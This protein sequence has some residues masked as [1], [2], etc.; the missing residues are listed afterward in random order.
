MYTLA[1]VVGSLRKASINKKLALALEKTGSDLFRFAP[2]DIGTIP[3]YNQDQEEDLPAAVQAMKDSIMKADAVL[4]LTPEYNRSI[5]GVLKNVLD[6]G[7]RPYGKNAWAGKPAAM[8]GSSA[9]AIG[10][11]VAQGHLRSVLGVLGMKL[12]VQPEL[13][14]QDIPE[15]LSED[16]TVR[17]ERTRGYL[18]AFLVSFNNWIQQANCDSATWSK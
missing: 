16:G 6:W 5:P 15:L 1:V 12:A 13:Y 10:T 8:A 11:A 2:L 3:L 18:R 14:F 7:S 17:D 4:F 9:G